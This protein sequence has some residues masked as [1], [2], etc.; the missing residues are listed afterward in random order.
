M[1]EIINLAIDAAKQAGNF[2]L[3]NFGKVS[4]VTEKGDR[5][6]AT[7]LDKEAEE[8]MRHMQMHS[9][10]EQVAGTMPG[11]QQAGKQPQQAAQMGAPPA[12]GAPGMN[13]PQPTA[14]RAPTE[15]EMQGGYTARGR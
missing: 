7:N 13:P 14:E 5:N 10:Y 8:M 9:F 12:G 4:E 3:E 11:Q 2:L 1:K 15:P 6:F